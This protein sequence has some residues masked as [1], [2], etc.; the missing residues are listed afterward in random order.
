[1]PDEN[2]ARRPIPGNTRREVFE[3]FGGKCAFCGTSNVPLDFAHNIP[4]YAGGTDDS[5]NLF[6]LCPNCHQAFSRG[7]ASELE[8]IAYLSK[9]L[10]SHPA[11]SDVQI[12]H[13]LP[14]E[15]RMRAD[16]TAVREAK[17]HKQS[18]LIECKNTP[19]L[20]QRR[21]TAAAAQ[22]SHYRRASSFDSYALTFPG[23]LS[24]EAQ[25]QLREARI[26]MWDVDFLAHEFQHQIRSIPHA[27]F[28]N[29][30]LGILA[31]SEPPIENTLLGRLAA[32]VPG[33]AYWVEYQQLVGTAL[34]HLFCPP[35]ESPISESG[36]AV[37]VNRRDWIFPNYADSGFWHFLRQM[38]KADY[39]VVDA[40]N[41]K[42]PISKT[43][44]LQIANYLK[45]HG[46]GMFAMIATRAGA[47]RSAD[48]TIKEQWGEFPASVRAVS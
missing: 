3:R 31:T 2:Q 13:P 11:Y 29:L 9:L 39:I 41:Y 14:S 7:G 35:L 42:G 15:P 6:L 5:S 34:Q 40:K 48:L 16:L 12:E 46:T 43:Q 37:A 20:D 47:D 8:F 22:I 17:G 45:P 10:S 18:I 21:L 28:S 36:D 33:K 26:E 23:R 27:Y 4:R 1:M 25:T 30:L 19:F 38:Y 24:T 32:C 44:V